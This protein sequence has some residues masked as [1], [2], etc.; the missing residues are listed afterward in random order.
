MSSV[1]LAVAGAAATSIAWQRYARL[2]LW[3]TWAPHLTAVISEHSTLASGIAG[4]V[5]GPGPLSA[6]FQ[7]GH[8]DPPAMTW[9]WW[10]RSGPLTMY[11]I[12]GLRGEQG[13]TVADLEL[14]GPFPLVQAYAP[15]ARWAL[16]RLVR[17]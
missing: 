13:G 11:L 14:R 15:V 8:V 17:P 7:V 9:D 16:E 4:I 1:R 6:R 10:V 3:P 12:H 2:E 5:R